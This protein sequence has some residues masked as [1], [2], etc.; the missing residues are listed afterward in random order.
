MRN[1]WH[2]EHSRKETG[3]VNAQDD[4]PRRLL[5]DLL[6]QARTEARLSQESVGAAVGVDRSGIARME[7]GQRQL[8][9]ASLTAWLGKC[10]VTGL[11]ESGI[12]A[13]WRAARRQAR[14]PEQRLLNWTGAEAEA[15]VLRFWHPGAVPG[16]L[17]T[18]EYAYET[19]RVYGYD[20]DSATQAAAARVERHRI[21][22][23][24]KPPRVVAVI[25][26]LVLHRQ[27]GSRE[28]MA[29]QCRLLLEL[30]ERP[31]V[32]VQVVRGASAGLGGMVALAEGPGGTV[33]LAGSV[34]EDIMGDDD[35]QV[36]AADA[37]IDAVRA[38]ADS[39]AGS[40]NII[41]EALTRWTA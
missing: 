10:D 11:A 38:V 37:I 22:D 15:R 20:H 41:G 23:R 28:V 30:G 9:S 12:R 1:D 40:R 19:Y 4:D 32:S 18:E 26:E 21:L 33:V 3:T 8:T 27:L 34:L 35:A 2:E 16:L 13:M 6:R 31:Q 14:E 7:A 36:Q 5:G 39:T 17:Q 29:G 24:D 25:D